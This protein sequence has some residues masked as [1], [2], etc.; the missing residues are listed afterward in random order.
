[1]LDSPVNNIGCQREEEGSRSCSQASC[2]LFFASKISNTE[3]NDE[4]KNHCDPETFH[5]TGPFPCSSFPL[6][7]PQVLLPNALSTV[8][9]NSPAHLFYQFLL[10][11]C[12][13]PIAR[14]EEGGERACSHS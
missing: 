9:I 3:S 8:P 7:S 6:A 13:L 2:D 5:S 10:S 11:H 4:S 14:V 1:M 12:V